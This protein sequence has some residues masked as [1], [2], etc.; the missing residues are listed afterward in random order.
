[1]GAISSLLIIM[2][3]LWAINI[4]KEPKIA[5]GV[6]QASIVNLEYLNKFK[7]KDSQSINILID[8]LEKLKVE[9]E[10]KYANAR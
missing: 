6:I 5:C 8:Y 1:M 3:A 10:N 9:I 2:V 7:L 4:D